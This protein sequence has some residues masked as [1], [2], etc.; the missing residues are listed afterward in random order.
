MMIMMMAGGPPLPRAL[1]EAV[2]AEE[3][4]RDPERVT[5]AVVAVVARLKR[6]RRHSPAAIDAAVA[7]VC[8]DLGIPWTP[9]PT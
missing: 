6:Q 7:Q 3:L 5:R 1:A 2:I 4:Q 9:K 8:R